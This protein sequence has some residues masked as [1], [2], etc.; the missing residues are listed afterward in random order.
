MKKVTLF[1]ISLSFLCA[2]FVQAQITSF[3]YIEGSEPIIFTEAEIVNTERAVINQPNDFIL[4]DDL[5]GNIDGVTAFDLTSINSEI[6]TDLDMVIT[7]YT[8]QDDA[9]NGVGA[10]TDSGRYSSAGE[11]IYVRVENSLTGTYD[12]TSFKLIVNLTPL[13]TFD[14]KYKYEINPNNTIVSD[15]GLVPSNFTA[16]QVTIKWYLDDALIT[17]ESGLI[18]SSVLVAGEY[19]AVITFKTS[20]CESTAV[21][22]KVVEMD[23]PFVPQGISPNSS[24]G[25]NDF[26]DLSAFDDVTKLEIFNRNGNVV[27]SKSNYTNEWVGQSKSGEELPVGTYFYSIEYDGGT[28]KRSGWVYLNR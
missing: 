1:L 24:P 5:D 13:A 25:L 16:D 4:C 22:A 6:S 23:S 20:G 19:K 8:S 18:L 14:P 11:T 27:Y 9:F 2:S 17:D 3:S 21:T 10:I 15:I 26:F 12:T 28:K 7:Y